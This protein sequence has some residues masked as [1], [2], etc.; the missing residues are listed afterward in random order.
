YLHQ[1]NGVTFNFGTGV[2]RIIG[3]GKVRA[4]ELT[5]GVEVPA[6]VVVVGIGIT[7]NV[8]LAEAAGLEISNGVVTDESL[9]TSD[10]DIYA[11]GDVASY[12]HPLLKTRI[13]V[14]HWSNALNGGKAAG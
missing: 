11:C 10:P 4:V 2:Q 3:D 8:E 13:R 6:D 9:R 7:P 14:E 5:T 12:W 1:A